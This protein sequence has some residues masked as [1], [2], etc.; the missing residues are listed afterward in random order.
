MTIE[1]PDDLPAPFDE[2]ADD[3]RA[4]EWRD[5]LGDL[6]PVPRF[7]HRPVTREQLVAAIAN[8]SYLIPCG[9]MAAPKESK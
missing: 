2:E 9:A 5:G 7:Q 4:D 1:C 6:K 8:P 3:R